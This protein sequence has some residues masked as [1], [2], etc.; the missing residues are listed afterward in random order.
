VVGGKPDPGEA[1]AATAHQR[2]AAGALRRHPPQGQEAQRR[3]ARRAGRRGDRQGL[4]RAT[5]RVRH[6]QPW[7]GER[8]DVPLRPARTDGED[9]VGALAWQRAPG[10]EGK[11]R[12]RGR[13][14]RPRG[15]RDPPDLDPG[16]EGRR[17]GTPVDWVARLRRPGGRGR[18]TSRTGRRSWTRRREAVGTYAAPRANVASA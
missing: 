9:G 18:S 10:G 6:G 2:D 4:P 1:G 12:R 17:R 7:A 8:A 15:R 13:R 5:G 3:G 11:A 16:A 14:R